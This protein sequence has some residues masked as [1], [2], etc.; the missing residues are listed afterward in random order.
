MLTASANIWKFALF[1]TALAVFVNQTFICHA[2]NAGLIP[3]VHAAD[4]GCAEAPEPSGEPSNES[5]VDGCQKAG[6]HKPVYA[7]EPWVMAI[8]IPDRHLETY[9]LADQILPESPVAEIEY[10]PQLS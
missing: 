7:P 9:T 6:C 1:V 5:P 8:L 10:P 2:E 4:Q 3:C